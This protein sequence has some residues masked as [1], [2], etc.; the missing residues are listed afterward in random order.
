MKG[1]DGMPTETKYQK[2]KSIVFTVAES[3]NEK[4]W[5]KVTFENG[6][7]WL[8]SLVDIGD[9]ISKIGKCEDVKYPNGKGHKFTQD[10]INKCFNKTR[11]Q[12]ILSYQKCFNPNKL[13]F[14][15]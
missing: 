13:K 2:I 8:P 9:I 11:S 10:F 3:P 4:N 15:H 6:T 1:Q 5:V 14:S 12:I 7:T